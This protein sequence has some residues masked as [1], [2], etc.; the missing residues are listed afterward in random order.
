MA[1][2]CF[3]LLACSQTDRATPNRHADDADAPGRVFAAAHTPTGTLGLVSL[4]AVLS[5]PVTNA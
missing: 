2:D 4:P 1:H 5:G 3:R